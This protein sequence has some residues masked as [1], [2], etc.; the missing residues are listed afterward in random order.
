MVV[1]AVVVVV[2]IVVIIATYLYLFLSTEPL[3]RWTKGKSNLDGWH[4][5]CESLRSHWP[6]GRPRLTFNE[7]R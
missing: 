2:P 5:F 6:P 3:G 4:C 7:K 1:I